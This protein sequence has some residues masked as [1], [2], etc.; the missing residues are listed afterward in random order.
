MEDLYKK[1]LTQPISLKAK[2]LVYAVG[3]IYPFKIYLEGNSEKE[4][5][6]KMGIVSF[7]ESIDDEE[8]TMKDSPNHNSYT[9]WTPQ[10]VSDCILELQSVGYTV[11]KI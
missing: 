11:S 5:A 2:L 8:T 4:L 9:T 10:M 1:L 6:N 7:K 3:R